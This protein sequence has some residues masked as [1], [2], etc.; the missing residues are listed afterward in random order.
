[1]KFTEVYTI[2]TILRLRDCEDS[3]Y[4]FQIWKKLFDPLNAQKR[5]LKY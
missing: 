2:Q 4:F 3:D 1:M 5:Q